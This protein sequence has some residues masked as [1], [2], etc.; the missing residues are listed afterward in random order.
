MFMSKESNQRPGVFD[1]E[2]CI[3]DRSKAA[4][5]A[6]ASWLAVATPD[7]AVELREALPEANIL[8][9]GAVTSEAAEVLVNLG[10]SLTVTSVQGL[11]VYK[12][13][14]L[15]RVLSLIVTLLPS[16]MPSR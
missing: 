5:E 2:M 10:V 4:L 6:G 12:R 1:S 11:D 9:L 7:E 14:G 15:K 8:V 16:K 3:R 13:Q